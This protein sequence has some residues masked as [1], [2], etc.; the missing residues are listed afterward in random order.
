MTRRL[1]L[2]LAALC[3]A[4]AA[5][6]SAQSR[7]T[8]A[9]LAGTIIDQSAAVLPGATVTAHNAETNYTR[10]GTTDDRGH[11]LIP[12]LPPG[13]YDVRAELAG[14]TP[15]TLEDVVL[16]LGSLVD[17]RLTLNVAGGQET[18][19]VTVDSAVIDSQRTVVSGVISQQQIERLPINS[20]N[21]IG[22]SLLDNWSAAPP[23]D[24]TT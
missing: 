22:F 8:S 2:S 20:R 24:E 12:A 19:T 4:L 1:E 21:F 15:R 10:S 18:V 23:G 14:F 5:E 3:L 11:F 9:D 17:V 16:T 7:A 6:T 13:T